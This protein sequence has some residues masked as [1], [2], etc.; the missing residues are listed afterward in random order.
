M[1]LWNNTIFAHASI[2]SVRELEM[3]MQSISA[4]RNV[5]EVSR[6]DIE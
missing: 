6:I 2:Y 5:D 4:I 1:W 3:A